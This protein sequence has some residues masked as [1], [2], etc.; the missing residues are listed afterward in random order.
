MFFRK[1]SVSLKLDPYFSLFSKGWTLRHSCYQCH[2]SNLQRV[3]DITIGDC[4][5]HA[6]Y[7][8]FH[9][10]E[11][12]S[13]VIIN[14][15]TGMNL[16]ECMKQHF[17]FID[18]DIQ[19][20]VEVNVQLKQSFKCPPERETIYEEINQL[21]IQEIKKRYARKKTVRSVV[22]AFLID[23]CPPCIIGKFVK[24]IR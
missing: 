5:S 19:K 14:T 8:S 23:Y 1:S 18:L 17:D 12:T 11:A 3:G 10:N 15:V 2:Y 13:V 24:L 16:W 9:P 7:P 22:G 4:D 21:S 6:N 20:E